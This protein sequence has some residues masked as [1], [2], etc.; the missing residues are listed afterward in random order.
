MTLFSD[1]DLTENKFGDFGRLLGL[2]GG[3]YLT[4]TVE[5]LMLADV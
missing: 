2:V 3:Q 5:K 1:L 4:Y